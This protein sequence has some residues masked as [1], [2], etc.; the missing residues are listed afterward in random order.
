M[1]IKLQ[2]VRYRCLIL[3][4]CIFLPLLIWNR[5][6]LI[7][8]NNYLAFVIN[9]KYSLVIHCIYLMGYRFGIELIVCLLAVRRVGSRNPFLEFC[10][11]YYSV[12]N[13]LLVKQM[14]ARAIIHQ[15]LLGSI[16]YGWLH[17]FKFICLVFGSQLT[18]Y[19]S[20]PNAT[21]CYPIVA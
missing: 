10:L 19:Y 15:L 12:R 16:Y 2:Y 1:D 20:Y 8:K 11:E 7:R 9:S 3:S 18:I 21:T 6:L 14:L 5:A 13:S 4:D 17:I